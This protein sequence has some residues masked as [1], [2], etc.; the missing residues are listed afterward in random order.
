MSMTSTE[1]PIFPDASNACL[2]RAEI[3]VTMSLPASSVKSP[4]TRPQEM[5]IAAL[6]IPAL[7]NIPFP[8]SASMPETTSTGI[9]NRQMLSAPQPPS[10]EKPTTARMATQPPALTGPTKPSSSSSTTGSTIRI[11][12]TASES[13]SSGDRARQSTRLSTVS[14]HLFLC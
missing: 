2:N 6:L 9:R 12:G 14:P 10:S 5:N 13:T 1:S 7:M 3:A 4:I 11:C 8:R